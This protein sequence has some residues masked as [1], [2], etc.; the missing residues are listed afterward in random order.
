[1]KNVFFFFRFSAWRFIDI[2]KVK[3]AA[4]PLTLQSFEN[5]V[6]QCCAEGRQKLKTVQV[7]FFK[8]I[9]F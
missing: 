9:L 4:A 6:D 5:L 7:L 2:S 1:M 8:K 3:N